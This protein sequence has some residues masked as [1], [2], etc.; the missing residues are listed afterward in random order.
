MQNS[1]GQ[2]DEEAFQYFRRILSSSPILTYPDFSEPFILYTDASHQA[3]GSVLAQKQQGVEKVVA[4]ASHV[5]TKTER[6]WATFDREWWAIVWSVRH[7]SHYLQGCPFVIVTDHRPLLGLRKM[8]IERDPTGRRARWALELD[9]YDWVIKHRDGVKHTNADS[10]SRRPG[11]SDS[12]SQ[13]TYDNTNS[14][15]SKQSESTAPVT[16]NAVLDLSEALSLDVTQCQTDDG[17]LRTVRDWLEEGKRPPA[18]VVKKSS[19]DLRVYW[20]QFDRLQLQDGKIYRLS[21]NRPKECRTLHIVIP[22]QVVPQVL[23]FL[24]GHS[25][26]GH[27]GHKKTLWRAKEHFYWPFMARDIEKYCQQ[28]VACQSRS[29]PVPHRVAPLQTIHANGP[30][31]KVAAD[32][33][34]LP[35]SPTGHR[36]V[37]VLQDYFTKYVNLYPMKDQRAVTVAHCIFEQYITEHGVPEYLHTDQGRQFEADLIKELCSK[38]GVNKTRTSPYHPE[39][40]GLIERFNRTLKDQLSKCLYQQAEPWDTML[41]SIQFSYNT[42]VHSSTG[43]TPFFLVHSR[44]ARLPVHLLFSTPV[45]PSSASPGTPAEYARSVCRKLQFAYRSRQENHEHAHAQQKAQYDKKVKYSSYSVG[46]LVWLSDAAHSRCKLAQRWKGP[47]VVTQIVQPTEGHAV[48]Y[49][50][51]SKAAPEKT[52]LVVHYNRLKPYLSPASQLSQP[53][54]DV[55]FPSEPPLAKDVLP[56]TN[57]SGTAEKE[58]LPSIVFSGEVPNPTSDRPL[59][60]E[61]PQSNL[62]P[63]TGHFNVEPLNDIDIVSQQLGHSVVMNSRPLGRRPVKPPARFKDFVVK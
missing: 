39:G 63:Q 15:E 49:A 61:Q 33:T 18:W 10:L 50:I 34:E 9:V 6:N 3:I 2:K 32:I 14:N 46:D 27:L 62:T 24:H 16:V 52:P 59:P 20:R 51:Q 47:Y 21:Y 45:E 7:F 48:L 5:L 30:F 31:E 12:I 28:C 36:Y 19:A 40:D 41:R 53:V 35:V 44:E 57:L 38:L 56:S 42:S 23:Q 4:Y 26:V 60:S 11:H 43:Y 58:N 25:T 1:Y 37:L 54:S 22:S 29:M 55:L 8:P 17:T 13:P